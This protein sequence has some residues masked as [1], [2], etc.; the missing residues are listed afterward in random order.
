M[1]F[2]SWLGVLLGSTAICALVACSGDDAKDEP[3]SDSSEVNG[4]EDLFEKTAPIEMKISSPIQTLFTRYKAGQADP[5][6]A[7]ATP[8]E[9]NFSEPAQIVVADADGKG[10]T[11]TFEA[12][13]FIRGES[14][15]H[16]CPFPKL[17]I[18]FSDKEALKGTLFKGHSKVRLNTHCGPGDENARSG[19]GRIQNG[20]GPVR[21]DLVYRLIRATDVPTYL[22]RVS[23]VVYDD[24]AAKTSIDTFGLLIESGDDTAERF[25]KDKLIEPEGQYLDPNNGEASG[26]V[27]P[28]NNGKIIVA[29]A[30]AG[31][32]DF[33][34]GGTHNLDSFGI[35]R[36][37]TIFKIPEDFDLCAITTAGAPNWTGPV[38]NAS[39]GLRTAGVAAHFAKHKADVLA[40]LDKAEKEYVAAKAM[41]SEDG[42]T[43]VD[44]GFKV[45]RERVAQLYQLPE[46]ANANAADAGADAGHD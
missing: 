45:A 14:S 40:A 1:R 25:V 46:L 33:W 36:A 21:E 10:T 22:T 4:R 12:R 39:Q 18:E 43:T 17:K 5:P 13:I 16:D 44:P 15:K 11:K 20:V 38:S 27:T 42:K 8:G 3:P 41:R 30:L 32:Q 19:Y 2:P 34:A 29:E 26:S 23:K 6:E 9:Q 24:T 35:P 37:A 28:D 7:D 31:N